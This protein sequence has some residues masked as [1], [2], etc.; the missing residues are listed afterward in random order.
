MSMVLRAA[1]ALSLTAMLCVGAPSEA[2]STGGSTSCG[3]TVI[4]GKLS[5]CTFDD[6]FSSTSLDR[7]KWVVN[8]GFVSGDATAYA[9]TV[10]DPR[11]ISVSGGAL[12]LT[13]AQVSTPVPCNGAAPANFE[14]PTI[15]TWHLFSQQ[16]GRFEV[17]MRNTATSQPG[18]QESFWLW[19]DDRYSVINWPVTGEIDVSETYSSYPTM[20]IPY[21]HYGLNDNGGPIPGVNTSWDCTAQRGVWNTYTLDWT[22]TSMTISVNGTTCL[23]NTSATS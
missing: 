17:R 5:R 13:A 15:S 11:Y 10:D 4:N 6:E 9:C 20:V 18:L 14:A 23:V 22:P 19:P 16:Y 8:T 21:L 2:A 12:H 3:Y 1:A 7:K